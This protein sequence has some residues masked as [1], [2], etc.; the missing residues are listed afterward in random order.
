[1]LTTGACSQ[2]QGHETSLATIVG[3]LW[4]IPPERVTVLLG[5]TGR[6][7]FGAGTYASRTLQLVSAAAVEATKRLQ[8]KL[9][10]IA[11]GMLEANPADL[12]LD[13]A[14]RR[15]A[16]RGDAA[17]AVSLGQV[18]QASGPGWGAR[19]PGR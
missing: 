4:G 12:E 17:R 14:C 11:A 2:G 19:R 18:V 7:P 6:I 16:V 9:R 3:E 8:D 5:D 10:G 13:L 15:L 1:V